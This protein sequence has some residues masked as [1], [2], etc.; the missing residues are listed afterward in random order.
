ISAA[1][2]SRHLYV[3]GTGGNPTPE[4]LRART[5]VATQAANWSAYRGE[6]AGRVMF[7][8]RVVADKDVR[9]SDLASANLILFGTKETNALIGKYS[10][11]LPLQ[12]NANATG[13]GLFY[14]FP[15]DGHYVAVSSGLPWWT[16][17]LAQGYP[18]VPPVQRV[19]ADFQD[20]ILFRESP[21]NVVA[22]GH[23]D[24]NW[25]T[26]EN[27]AKALTATGVVTVAPVVSSVK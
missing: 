10:D 9:P 15:V 4:E 26:P 18:F 23:F 25:R 20:F 6:F 13:Y 7:F 8:P 21:R 27:E 16:G 17:L 24:A 2:A 12:L 3:Y 14:V 5:E 1:F 11:R 22:E 19:L